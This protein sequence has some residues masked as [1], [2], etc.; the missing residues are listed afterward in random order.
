MSH[1]HNPCH[2]LLSA[3][4]RLRVL[5]SSTSSAV[6]NQ[7]GPP[8]HR[9]SGSH[10]DSFDSRDEFMTHSQQLRVSNLIQHGF[11]ATLNF[12]AWWLGQKM[13]HHVGAWL[14]VKTA[15]MPPCGR[16]SREDCFAWETSDLLTS[17][18]LVL[19]II[20]SQ[21]KLCGE[22]LSKQ[23]VFSMFESQ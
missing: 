7:S 8:T 18:D 21:R 23:T 6:E 4:K 22:P 10:R 2:A 20:N 15:G 9:G 1:E 19:K 14:T 13:N 5:A 12:M 16:R 3:P 11:S 17:I